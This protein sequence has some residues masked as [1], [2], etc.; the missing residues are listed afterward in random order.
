MGPSLLLPMA[1]AEKEI[2]ILNEKFFI[3][4][5]NSSKVPKIPAMKLSEGF[6]VK[7]SDYCS[8][9]KKIE[10]GL[11]FTPPHCLLGGG[12]GGPKFFP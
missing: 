8:F 6:G 12:S 4:W 2:E 1:S 11:P 9:F 7:F 3:V 10:I 5:K